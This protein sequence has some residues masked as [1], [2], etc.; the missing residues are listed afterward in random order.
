MGI[1]LTAVIFIS[2]AL[3]IDISVKSLAFNRSNSFL[4]VLD[5]RGDKYKIVAAAP[6]LIIDAIILVLGLFG[7]VDLN[8]I[9]NPN[10]GAINE[11]IPSFT[12]II[13]MIYLY[14]N[15]AVRQRKNTLEY[16]TEIIDPT[17]IFKEANFMNNVNGLVLVCFG[18][19]CT[20]VLFIKAFS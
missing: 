11:I 19:I 5:R 20:W 8:K 4:A 7:Q 14:T 6:V 2:L 10:H 15:Y 13:L 18:I 12:M 3:Y 9:A 1:L 16:S 17:R